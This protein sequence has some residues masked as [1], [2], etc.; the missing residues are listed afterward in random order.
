MVYCA[1]QIHI[2]TCL[3]PL[4]STLVW[5]DLLPDGRSQC[6]IRITV[7]VVSITANITNI[8]IQTTDC[9]AIHIRYQT[10]V[11]WMSFFIWR[12]T[13]RLTTV[14]VKIRSSLRATKSA[15]WTDFNA[16]VQLVC[17]SR[18][19]EWCSVDIK[20]MLNARQI[21]TCLR[22]TT[23]LWFVCNNLPISKIAFVH[24]THAGKV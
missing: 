11:R 9:D 1:I 4:L 13:K 17:C 12:K 15:V 19:S 3:Y 5:F 10:K 2:F 20:W 22:L 7:W 24:Y 6:D 8:C 18:V 23:W 16:F 14:N 21:D